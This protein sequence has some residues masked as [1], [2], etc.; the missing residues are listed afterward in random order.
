MVRERLKNIINGLI[1]LFDLKVVNKSQRYI[2]E[3]GDYYKYFATRESKTATGFDGEPIAWMTY[4]ALEY[5]NQ[6]NFKAKTILEFGSGNSTIWLSKKCK[7]I[8]SIETDM[9]WY[10]YVNASKPNNAEIIHTNRESIAD[11]ATSLNRKFDIVVNDSYQRERVIEVIDHL[12]NVDGILIFDN[13]DRY[14]DSCKKL[15]EKGFLQVDFKGF[16]PINKYTWTTSV[17]F[18]SL[19]NIELL[20]IQPTLSKG[21][22]HEYSKY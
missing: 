8:V 3:V 9:K 14:P 11:T 21:N 18:S 2:F 22:E 10:D 16:G 6:F 19:K 5:L 13:S 7:E 1:G 17:F 4:P 20:S 15:R 12:L